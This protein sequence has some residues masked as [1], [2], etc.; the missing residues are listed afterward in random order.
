MR[1]PGTRE[2]RAHLFQRT[3]IDFHADNRARSYVTSISTRARSMASVSTILVIGI[4]V[5]PPLSQR[6][7]IIGWR[8]SANA[9]A[10]VHATWLHM[11]VRVTRE[12]REKQKE[13]ENEEEEEEEEEKE[14]ETE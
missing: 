2:A 14:E 9:D 6:R 3:L 7:S 5:Q 13:K 4:R 1:S 11:H 10:D 12:R 8:I